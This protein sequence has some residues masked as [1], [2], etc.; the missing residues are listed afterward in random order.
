MSTAGQQGQTGMSVPPRRNCVRSLL[1]VDF[2]SMRYTLFAGFVFLGC[3]LTGLAQDWARQ[4][5]EKSPRHGE[6]VTVKHGNRAVQAFI[7]YPEVK[8]KAS[9]VVVIHEIFGLT[10]WVRGV[11]DQLAA[12]GYIAIAPDLLTGMGP[13]GGRAGGVGRVDRARE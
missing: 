13:N 11:A 2:A 3:A 8:G 1:G 12:A 9:A 6:W 4:A 10:D 5:L 7:V